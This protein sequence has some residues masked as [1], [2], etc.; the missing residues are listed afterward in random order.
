MPMSD[1]ATSWPWSMGRNWTVIYTNWRGKTAVRHIRVYTVRFGTA[2]WHDGPQ[3][4]VEG[5]D[6]DTN[7]EREFALKNMRPASG[8]GDHENETQG[9]I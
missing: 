3:W 9:N 6:K 1:P 4:I 5:C 8:P 7:T 2:Q